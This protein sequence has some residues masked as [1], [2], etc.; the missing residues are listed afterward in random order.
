MSM[1]ILMLVFAGIFTIIVFGSTSGSAHISNIQLQ[2]TDNSSITV[3]AVF[4]AMLGAFWAYQGWAAVGYVGGE[5]KD[6]KKNIPRGIAIGMFTVI[7]V[8]LL[9][10]TTY[11]TLLST[12]QL[13]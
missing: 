9:V 12:Q 5:I 4:T 6:A 11:L 13:D 2:T 1:A 3:S 8:Y 7:A 10:N